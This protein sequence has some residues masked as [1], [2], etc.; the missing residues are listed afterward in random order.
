MATIAG[1]WKNPPTY[2][3]QLKSCLILELLRARSGWNAASYERRAASTL[4]LSIFTSPNRVSIINFL[5]HLPCVI[6][7][8]L[9]RKKLTYHHHMKSQTIASNQGRTHEPNCFFGRRYPSQLIHVYFHSSC[10][11]F[12]SYFMASVLHEPVSTQ[13]SINS[14]C[15]SYHEIFQIWGIIH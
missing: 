10:L 8:I 1:P 7:E 15:I 13:L 9:I 6:L 4:E 5:R 11:K 2:V 12:C 14:T 3:P